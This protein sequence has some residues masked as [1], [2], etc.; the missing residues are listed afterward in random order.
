[1]QKFLVGAACG[2]DGRQ[3]KKLATL[4]THEKDAMRLTDDSMSWPFNLTRSAPTHRILISRFKRGQR[5][6]FR[7]T[8]ID[9]G[10]S[11]V[12]NTAVLILE[13]LDRSYQHCARA[14]CCG[15]VS[16]GWT[17]ARGSLTQQ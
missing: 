6:G 3:E 8:A 13:Q 9:G 10:S 14:S 17:T 2:F 4:G 15:T 11:E 7:T 12:E 16:S 1:M 5:L